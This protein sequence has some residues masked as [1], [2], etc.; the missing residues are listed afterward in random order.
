MSSDGS[1]KDEDK[2][3]PGR[4]RGK[5]SFRPPPPKRFYKVAE[6]RPLEQA[7]KQPGFGVFLDG[8]AVKTPRKRPLA[9]P[10][11]AFGEAVAAEWAR[12][13]KLID[14][15]TMPLTRIANTAIDAVVDMMPDVAADIVAFAGSDLLCYRAVGM[16]ELAA[17]QSRA[18]DGVLSWALGELNARFILTE[19]VMP[20][21]QPKISLGRIA[22][23]LEDYD[24]FQLSSLHVMTTLTGSALLALAHARGVLSREAAWA[25]AHVDE[26][27]QIEQWGPDDEAA[28]RRA[29]RWVEFEAAS[30]VLA[31]TKQA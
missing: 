15:A 3:A 8:R 9:V 12:Q 23:T 11:Q 22:N 14:P 17:R 27:W 2:P 7:N 6:A 10:S 21:E 1:R 19:G 26:D 29:K 31:F 16:Q 30:Q 13:D 28:G 20:V 25:A 18:W 24:A 4:V 5:E